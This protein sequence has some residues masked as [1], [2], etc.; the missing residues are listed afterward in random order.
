MNSLHKNTVLIVFL[1]IACTAV[2]ALAGPNE[3]GPP[4]PVPAIAAPEPAA[5]PAVAPVAIQEE[6]PVLTPVQSQLL[7]TFGWAERVANDQL[8]VW[9]SV[10]EQRTRVIRNGE[11]LL[12]KPCA[13]AANGVGFEMGSK[14]T[15]LGWHSVAKKIGD[16]APWGQVFRS[17]AATN[18]IWKPGDDT[19]QDL[20]LTRILWLTG[21]EPG[22]NRGG[23][24]DSYER[25]IY[26]HGT[27]AEDLIGAPS[28]HGCIRMYNDDVIEAFD[29]IPEGALVL[30]TTE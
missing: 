8:A 24:V 1:M 17:R 14:K 22:K 19:K 28:S 2:V 15:P 13:T 7:D 18:E 10:A 26:F 23:S 4:R 16:G 11:I 3:S 30:I 29:L 25:Y 27:N 9:V 6:V 21:E 20:V 5:P 12:D